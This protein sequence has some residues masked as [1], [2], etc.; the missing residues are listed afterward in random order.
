MTQANIINIVG[1]TKAHSLE[2]L[3]RDARLAS[4]Y[5]DLE[6]KL[7]DLKHMARIAFEQAAETVQDIFDGHATEGKH[8]DQMMFAVGHVEDMIRGLHQK[9][10]A[11]LQGASQSGDTGLT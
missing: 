3:E 7:I 4:A 9:W 11:G 10:C 8:Y 6:D 2:R 1:E 5:R